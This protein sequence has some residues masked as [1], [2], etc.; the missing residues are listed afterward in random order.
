MAK[1]FRCYNCLDDKGT[2]GRDFTATGSPVCPD[3]TLDGTPGKEHAN[4][5]V[6]LRTL[7]YDPKHHV[8]KCRGTGA[9]VC[10]APRISGIAMTGNPNVVNC[11]ACMATETFK[12][13]LAEFNIGVD[14]FQPPVDFTIKI[15]AEKSQYVKAE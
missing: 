7:H 11:P 5:I 15:D 13:E 9:P 14:D 8:V 4:M 3:C 6:P 12:T 10:G 1:L 2:P